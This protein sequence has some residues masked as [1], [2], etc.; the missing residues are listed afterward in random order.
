[1]KKTYKKPTIYTIEC[2]NSENILKSNSEVEITENIGA[3]ENNVFDND[4]E[5]LTYQTNQNIWENE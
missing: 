5:I 4:D 2:F 3:K 1:M